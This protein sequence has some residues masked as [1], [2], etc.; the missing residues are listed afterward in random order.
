MNFCCSFNPFDLATK[1][2][3]LPQDTVPAINFVAINLSAWKNYQKCPQERLRD[4]EAI[5]RHLPTLTERMNL[6]IPQIYERVD[7]LSVSGLLMLCGANNGVR[8]SVEVI[9]PPPSDS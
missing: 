8:F 1:P 3:P 7:L 2:P 9:A 6:R 5:R 4:V